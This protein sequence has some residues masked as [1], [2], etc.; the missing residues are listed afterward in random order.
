[1]GDSRTGN[2]Q[3]YNAAGDRLREA[4]ESRRRRRVTPIDLEC[5]AGEARTNARSL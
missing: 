4:V 1:M 2:Q 5:Q 3:D